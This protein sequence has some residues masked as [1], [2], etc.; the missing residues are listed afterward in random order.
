MQTIQ[1]VISQCIMSYQ[2]ALSNF[3]IGKRILHTNSKPISQVNR[4]EVL[5]TFFCNTLPYGQTF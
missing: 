3:N 4:S 1:H 2:K 5:D